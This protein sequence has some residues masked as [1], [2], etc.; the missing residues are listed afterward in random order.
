[1]RKQLSP[2]RE[3]VAK[4]GGVR[5]TARALELHPSAV[6]KWRVS[7]KQKGTGGRI[8]QRH[9]QALLAH[10]KKERIELTLSDLVDL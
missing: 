1:M 7:S 2:A 6:S 8:P 3:V 5:A 9:W 10:A 4:C